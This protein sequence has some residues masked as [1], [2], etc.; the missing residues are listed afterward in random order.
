[1]SGAIGLARGAG[2]L[3]RQAARGSAG[4]TGAAFAIA[5]ERVTALEAAR[6]YGLELR[7]GRA[8]CLFHGGEGY[9]LSFHGG[10][11]HCFVCGEAGDSVRF[12]QLFHGLA[13]P[14]DA[15]RALDR[16]FGLGLGLE[17]GRPPRIGQTAAAE[18]RRAAAARELA[19]WAHDTLWGYEGN[20][21]AMQARLAPAFLGEARHPM[22]DSFWVYSL[23]WHEHARWLL[24]GLPGGV[25]GRAAFAAEHREMLE[26]Y[27]R[28]NEAA[29]GLYG[30]LAE[31]VLAHGQERRTA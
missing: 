5:R 18:A 30:L 1:M 22:L 29:D 26:K 21:L 7:H 24:D 11:F 15:L 13:R 8:R 9:N 23:H 25:E 14:I 27:A 4:D 31:G 16:D 10:G 19:A 6:R 17:D 3:P 28:F 2:G 12:A 20:L